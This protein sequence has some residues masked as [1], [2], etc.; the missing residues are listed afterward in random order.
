MH[1]ATDHYLH[2]CT[3]V[4]PVYAVKPDKQYWSP[5]KKACLP[6]DSK[7]FSWHM[8]Q[9]TYITMRKH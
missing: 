3:T 4:Y 1:C 6:P 2:R 5:N 9:S 7:H 8:K